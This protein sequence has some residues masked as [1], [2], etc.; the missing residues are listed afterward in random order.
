[1][2]SHEQRWALAIDGIKEQIA[3]LEQRI[4]DLKF[5][6]YPPQSVLLITR[7]YNTAI[8]ELQI[9]L[10]RMIPLSENE[11]DETGTTDETMEP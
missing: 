8:E 5:S 9:A 2:L 4:K 11:T 3:R 6:E 1:M 10:N 7:Q